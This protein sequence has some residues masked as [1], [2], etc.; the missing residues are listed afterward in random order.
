ML[1]YKNILIISL[2]NG[3]CLYQNV[4]PLINIFKSEKILR[5]SLSF[6]NKEKNASI[7]LIDFFFLVKRN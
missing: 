5:F 1:A 7:K 2:E 6:K 4:D 3:N